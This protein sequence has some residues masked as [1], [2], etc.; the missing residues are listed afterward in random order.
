MARARTRNEGDVSE[1]ERAKIDP[2]YAGQVDP[3]LSRDAAN[4]TYSEGYTPPAYPPPGSA[5]EQ[6][7]GQPTEGTGTKEP[8]PAKK[9]GS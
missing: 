5:T 3:T 8:E 2:G 7:L 4:S 6:T 1:E 9:A